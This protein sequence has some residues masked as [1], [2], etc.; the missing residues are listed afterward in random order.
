MVGRLEL[1]GLKL[2]LDQNLLRIMDTDVFTVTR[3]HRHQ[4]AAVDERLLLM[5]LLLVD[6]LTDKSRLGRGRSLVQH[7]KLLGL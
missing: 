4:F 2:A 7:G 5:L 3:L 6:L 1:L